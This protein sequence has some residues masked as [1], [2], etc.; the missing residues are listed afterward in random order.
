MGDYI[1]NNFGFALVLPP[2]PEGF[3]V[4]K[5]FNI[6]TEPIDNK[7]FLTE[8]DAIRADISDIVI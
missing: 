5:N 3:T 7:L 2:T 4:T 6:P 8:L 1:N